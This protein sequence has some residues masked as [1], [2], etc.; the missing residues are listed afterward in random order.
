MVPQME[1]VAMELL[2]PVEVGRKC[3]YGALLET[4][5]NLV[6]CP[7]DHDQIVGLKRIQQTTTIQEAGEDHRLAPQLTLKCFPDGNNLKKQCPVRMP[8]DRSMM[9]TRSPNMPGSLTWLA[10][11]GKD[12]LD[13][14]PAPYRTNRD[15]SRII[16]KNRMFGQV[17]K[18]SFGI[19]VISGQVVCHPVPDGWVNNG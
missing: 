10:G 7:A 9:V 4:T 2:H 19:I 16:G 5:I 8:V 18:G 14:A 13:E 3:L 6:G 1:D 12:M 17:A 11:Q 15:R